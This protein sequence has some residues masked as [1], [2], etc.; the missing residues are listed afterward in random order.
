VVRDKLDTI[1][2]MR[3]YAHFGVEDL[4]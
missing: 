3:A 2:E 1:P 4:G